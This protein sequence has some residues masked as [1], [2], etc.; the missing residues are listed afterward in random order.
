MKENGIN[1]AKERSRRYPAQSTTYMDYADDIALPANSP[2]EAESILHSLEQATG[3]IELYVNADRVEYMCFN[4]KGDISTLKG[5]PLKLKD[6]FT[7]Q[8]SI[9]SSTENDINT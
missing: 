1:L 7:Y 2:T 6:K 5:D 4:Q 3:D 8:G 9:V